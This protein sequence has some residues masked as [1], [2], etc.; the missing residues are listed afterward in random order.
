MNFPW[1]WARGDFNTLKVHRGEENLIGGGL[2]GLDLG[3]SWGKRNTPGSGEL[4][5]REKRLRLFLQKN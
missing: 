3:T 1:N 5:S 4:Q 2:S